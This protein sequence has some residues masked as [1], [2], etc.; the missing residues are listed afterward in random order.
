MKFNLLALDYDGTIAADGELNPEVRSALI[1]A[2]RKEITLILATGRIL[3][4]LQ[5]LPCSL[6]LFDAVVAEN[7]AVGEPSPYRTNHPILLTGLDLLP[8]PART[9]L[10]PR[11]WPE[12]GY[13]RFDVRFLWKDH[14]CS[15]PQFERVCV[16]PG[17]RLRIEKW[18]LMS[19]ERPAASSLG[20][21]RLDDE[22]GVKRI[23]IETLSALWATVNNLTRLR[24]TKRERYRVTIFGSAR[25]QPGHFVYQEVKRMASGLTEM[26]CDI[27]TGGG[28]GL[29]EA[30]NAGAKEAGNGGRTQNIGIRVELPFEQEVNPFVTEAFQHQTFFTRLHHFVLISDAFIVAPG[31]IGTVLESMMIWQLLQVRHLYE[32]PLI[33]VGPM[34]RG[35]VEWAQASMLRPGFE[36][37]SPADMKIPLC[38]DTADQALAIIQQSHA[39]W[40]RAQEAL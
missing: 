31:G 4:D 23:L 32:T 12:L 25:T 19:H 37:A 27:V 28:P 5:R 15:R 35:L 24:P 20:T 21:V 17:Y 14:D 13:D 34:W 26:G 18:V 39:A 8:I 36:L 7:G 40:G 33:F 16:R 3:G 10:E 22:E 6:E 38:V 1:E 11:P 29:M 2:R 9:V 30:A